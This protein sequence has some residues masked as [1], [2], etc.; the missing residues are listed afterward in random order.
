M[1]W[2]DIVADGLSDSWEVVKPATDTNAAGIFKFDSTDQCLNGTAKVGTYI[3]YLKKNGGVV[4][5]LTISAI[6]RDMEV[7][8]T[9][10][11]RSS[12]TNPGKPVGGS[13][14]F[15]TNTFNPPADWSESMDGL[16][17]TIWFSFG[18]IYSTNSSSGT[19]SE[20][21]IYFD[22]DH[23]DIE[24]KVANVAVYRTL[25]SDTTLDSTHYPS[26]GSYTWTPSET[27]NKPDHWY[28][29]PQ[30]SIDAYKNSTDSTSYV[31]YVS[32]NTYKV[33][34]SNGT[35]Y[36][37][38]TSLGWTTPVKYLDIDSILSDAGSRAQTIVDDAIAE[39]QDSLETA[40]ALIT[41]GG[42][43]SVVNAVNNI[44]EWTIVDSATGY[45]TITS[46]DTTLYSPFGNTYKNSSDQLVGTIAALNADNNI[47]TS[48]YFNKCILFDSITPLTGSVQSNKYVAYIPST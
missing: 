16:T 18:S 35:N 9:T 17:G 22:H 4:A 47:C 11:Y 42:V 30:A 23:L 37:T 38:T 48:S 5:S 8:N 44:Y 43:A 46:S 6:L 1:S 13:Y 2:N 28:L 40:A 14:N 31:T 36:G 45:T 24:H 29:T 20:P 41:G 26:G 32:Y 33:D 3:F 12:Q 21:S 25:S 10:I 39:A 27:F 15:N 19:W 34:V 7:Y